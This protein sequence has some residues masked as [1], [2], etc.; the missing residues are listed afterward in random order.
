MSQMIKLTFYGGVNEIGGNKVLLEDGD[1]RLFFDF[2]TSFAKRYR[3]FE[4]YLK[5]RAGAGLLDLLELGLLPPLQGLYREDLTCG[6][7][8]WR[9]FEPIASLAEVDGV[10]VSHAHLDHSGYISFLRR[11]IP[12][13]ATAMTSFIAKAIQD[14]GKGDF[15]KEVCYAIP[16]EEREGVFQSA[17]WKREAAQ[18]RGFKVLDPEALTSEAL[19]FWQ[20]LPGR[21]GLEAQQLSAAENKIGSL[22]LRHFPVDHSI[23]GAAAFAVETSSGWVAYTGDMRF[24]GGK[25]HLTKQFIKEAA[26]LEP[27]VLICEGTNVESSARVSEDE[28]YANALRA[29]KNAK[30]LVIADFGPR[31]IERLRTFRQIA[32]ATNRCLVILAK[33]AYLLKAMRYISQEVPSAQ[34]KAIAV[35]KDAKAKLDGWERDVR[36]EYRDKLVTPEQIRQ[37][38]DSYILCFSFFD[39]NE[40]PSLMPGEGSI[41][42]Y[43]S[44]EAH[45][46]EQEMDFWRLHHWLRH[47]RIRGVGL[48]EEVEPSKWELSK[49]ER[50]LHASGHAIG[51]ELLDLIQQINPRVLIPVHTEKP[52][53]FQQ[54]EGIGIKVRIAKEGETLSFP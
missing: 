33:D 19:D 1:T 36:R 43:S 47:F 4:E 7:D 34:D 3:Y 24:H 8:L 42:L 23:Y 11:E 21:R 37:G 14:S 22:R 20:H 13:Y 30:A 25:G 45:N 16:K 5:P 28:V 49:G 52:E 38:Q 46:E 50:G 35:Y 41:Y 2:G 17:D 40:L 31:N 44:S 53:Y 9:R 10:L 51:P 39:I 18:Q 27:T 15:E 26:R 32:E 29:V 54:L 6:V 12:I 48:P